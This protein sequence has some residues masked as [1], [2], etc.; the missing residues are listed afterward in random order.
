MAG[1]AGGTGGVFGGDGVPGD[2]FTGGL[3]GGGGG[4][5]GAIFLR[6]G[7]L[8][9]VECSFM[10]NRAQGGPGGQDGLGKGGAIFI[11]PFDEE[12][13]FNIA[14]LQAQTYQDDSASDLVEDA[15]YDN[16]DFYVAQTLLALKPGSP[17]DLL[18]RR[19]RQAITTG[20]PWVRQAP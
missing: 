16:N 2:G 14:M 1:A 9:L 11:Y 6:S 15:T 5:G 13:P 10:G 4:M 7:T 12:S 20:T 17:F 3:G 19:Y 18:Y 8:N